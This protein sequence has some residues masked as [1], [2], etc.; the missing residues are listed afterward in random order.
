MLTNWEQTLSLEYW[1]TVSILTDE[2]VVKVPFASGSFRPAGIVKRFLEIRERDRS[3]LGSLL[4]THQLH[5]GTY[6]R[7]IRRHAESGD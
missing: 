4:A 3:V 7:L 2:K 1:S 5:D 6:N